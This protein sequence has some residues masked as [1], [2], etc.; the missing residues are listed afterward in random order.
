MR[1][2]KDDGIGIQKLEFPF[3]TLDEAMIE[4]AEHVG[5]FGGIAQ[6]LAINDG[7]SLEDWK[8]WFRGYDITKPLAVI[9]FTK[10]R[11]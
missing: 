6:T 10:F 7:L 1:L 2:T 3:G 4:D 9:N 5:M 8:A 11:Y